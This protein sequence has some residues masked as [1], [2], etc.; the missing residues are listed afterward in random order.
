MKIALICPVYDLN[1]FGY[2]YTA[3]VCLPSLARF[4]D[5]L[6]LIQSCQSAPWP[7]YLYDGRFPHVAHIS[8]EYTHFDEDRFDVAQYQQNLLIGLTR[9]RR[10]GCD[11]AINISCNWYIPDDVGRTLRDIIQGMVSLPAA[12]AYLCVRY[13]LAGKLSNV[14]VR[15]P[16][17]LN[18]HAGAGWT[19]GVTD[20]LIRGDE[21]LTSDRTGRNA[22]GDGVHIA[23]RTAV[24]DAGYN[25]TIDDLQ[26]KLD[27]VRGYSDILRK[28]PVSWDW[29]YWHEYYRSK[30]AAMPFSNDELSPEGQQIADRCAPDFLSS[31][32]VK[33]L[34]L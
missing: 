19:F 5:R 7:L 15:H 31:I 28:R 22:Y 8:N 34:E 12:Y 29:D 13:Q 1:R 20:N 21:V 23:N 26:Q 3:D 14:A 11:V 18:L 32:L 27:F 25:I 6:Y 10:D 24:I 9:A 4:A 17:I 33:E 2:Q 16:A 30:V